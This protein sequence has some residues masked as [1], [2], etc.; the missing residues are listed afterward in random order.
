MR[1]PFI[2]KTINTDYRFALLEVAA[3]TPY[4]LPIPFSHPLINLPVKD[5]FLPPHYADSDLEI[6]ETYVK[7]KSIN[8]PVVIVPSEDFNE[9]GLYTVIFGDNRIPRV[10]T[11]AVGRDLDLY[12]HYLTVDGYNNF[13]EYSRFIVSGVIKLCY[14]VSPSGRL[15]IKEQFSE[16]LCK[17]ENKFYIGSIIDING[18][19]ISTPL[20]IWEKNSNT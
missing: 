12:L 5:G 8:R 18:I 1:Y 3:P 11:K 20:K 7:S 19:Q 14:V 16:S 13:K 15:I 6:N 10:S 9:T 2:I 17:I 4:I